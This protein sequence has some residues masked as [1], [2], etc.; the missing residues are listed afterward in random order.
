MTHKYIQKTRLVSARLLAEMFRNRP[1]WMPRRI[2][3]RTEAGN[4]PTKSSTPRMSLHILEWRAS[5]HRDTPMKS[6]APR[7]SQKVLKWNGS[8]QKN[9][10]RRREG[11]RRR[12]K[13]RDFEM[14]LR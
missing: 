7:M 13:T 2:P 11:S 10:S 5:R 9:E 8:P 3:T 4:T 1:L 12:D 14:E 6:N